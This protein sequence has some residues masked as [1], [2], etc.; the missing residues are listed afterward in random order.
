MDY[1]KEKIKSPSIT[2]ASDRSIMLRFEDG[3]SEY[4]HEH[5]FYFHSLLV[6]KFKKKISNQIRFFKVK[7]KILFRNKR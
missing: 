4:I 6:N 1:Q 2:P 3:I 7:K 5:V